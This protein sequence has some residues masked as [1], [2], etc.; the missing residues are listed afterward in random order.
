MNFYSELS[1]QEG[2]PDAIAVVCD[3]CNRP[4]PPAANREDALIAALKSGWRVRLR[5][6]TNDQEYLALDDFL[7]AFDTNDLICPACYKLEFAT[8][9]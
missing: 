2:C 3:G 6:V 1:L 7:R 8:Q 4:S 5:H 9:P